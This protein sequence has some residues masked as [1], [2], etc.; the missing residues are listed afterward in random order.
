LNSASWWLVGAAYPAQ[1]QQLP[2]IGMLSDEEIA[3]VRDAG[4]QPGQR[5]L[6]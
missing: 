3:M 1:E 6:A 4:K 5:N 2:V